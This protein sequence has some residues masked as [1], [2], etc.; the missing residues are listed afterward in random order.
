MMKQVYY[1][2]MVDKKNKDSR[3]QLE[4]TSGLFSAKQKIIKCLS[5]SYSV[6]GYH[7]LEFKTYSKQTTDI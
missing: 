5:S 7:M 3:W 1:V 4:P 6:W 2:L